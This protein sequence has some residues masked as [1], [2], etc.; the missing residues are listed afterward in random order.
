M[1][2]IRETGGPRFCVTPPTVRRR[3]VLCRNEYGGTRGRN[4]SSGSRETRSYRVKK[5]RRRYRTRTRNP[6][7]SR[8]S[9]T[10]IIVYRRSCKLK[11][12]NVRRRILF[13]TFALKT[14]TEAPSST[15]SRGHFAYSIR[16]PYTVSDQLHRIV[17]VFRRVPC[18]NV[19]I[20][21][22]F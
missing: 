10:I 8:P 12:R 7:T 17:S 2:T 9:V 16:T 15:T 18:S 4:T 20:R 22:K 21:F 6:S 19:R 1:K 3:R 11:K 14:F 5:T 13:S